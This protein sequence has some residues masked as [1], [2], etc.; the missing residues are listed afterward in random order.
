MFKHKMGTS[1]HKTHQL[2]P[3]ICF[4]YIDDIFFIWTRGEE[5]F[6]LFLKV[7]NEFHSNLKFT[8]ETSQNSVNFLDLNVSLKD[9]AIFTDLH[10]KPTDGHQFLHY[11]LILAT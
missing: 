7:I 6:N 11:H 3:F 1:F 10:I 8:Y 9:G 4:S 5:Q 2:Q